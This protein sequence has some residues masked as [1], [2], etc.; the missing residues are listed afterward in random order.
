MSE[1]E[2]IILLE[3]DSFKRKKILSLVFKGVI[4]SIS[5]II[6]LFLVINSLEYSFQFGINTRTFLFFFYLLTCII[7]LSLYIGIP[8]SKLLDINKAIEDESAAKIIGQNFPEISDKLLNIIQLRKGSHEVGTLAY[9]GI[10][11]KID[12]IPS[13]KFD[14]A[15][16]NEANYKLLPWAVVPIIILVIV[17]FYRPEIITDS[18][19]R[20]TNY[21]KEYIPQAPFQFNLLNT[22]LTAF[23]N[24]DFKLELEITGNV[25][26]S[27][28]YLLDSDR[29]LKLVNDGDSRFSFEFNKIQ[30]SKRIKFEAAGFISKT[31]SIDVFNRPDLKSFNMYLEY[32]RYLHKKDERLS[33]V[34]NAQ[35]P[36]GT[37]VQWELRASETDSVLIDFHNQEPKQ[38]LQLS[39][40]ELFEYKSVITNSSNYEIILI[41]D[42]SKNRDQ[43]LYDLDV[44]KDAFPKINNQIYQD[45]ILYKIIGIG[46]S[47]IDDYGITKLKLF[48][49]I[50]N[51]SYDGVTI[52]LVNNEPNQRF[53]YTWQIDSLI[54]DNQEISYYL[55]VWDNDG[56]NGHKSTKTST[57]KLKVPS[58][59]E[60]KDDIDKM[61]QQTQSDID[62]TLKNAKELKEKLDE[63]ERKVKGK[64]ELNWQEN[65]LIKDL[66]ERREEL[67][68]A[69][70]ELKE[71]NRNNEMKR[72]RFSPQD[73]KIKEKVEQLQNLMDELLDE[74]TKKLYDELKRLLEEQENVEDIQELIEKINNKET[75]LENELERTLELFKKMKF[76]FDL[77]ETIA[78]LKEQIFDQEMLMRETERNSGKDDEKYSTLEQQEEKNQY[79][80]NNIKDKSSDYLKEKQEILQEDFSQLEEKLED[81]KKQNQSLKNPESLPD[82]E[83]NQKNVKEN[84]KESLENLKDNQRSKSKQSQQKAKDAMQKMADQL[85]KMQQGMEMQAMQENLDDLR[86]IIHNLIKLSFD[87][88]NLMNE[89]REVNQSDPRFVE[90][91]QQQLKLK[92][93]SQI[94][95]D[96][97]LALASRVFQ[98]ASFVT[99]E[100]TEMN[101]RMDKS[102]EF[103][104]ERKKP[105]AIAEQQFAMTSMNNLA[106]LLDDVLQQMQNAMADAMGK[107]SKNKGNQKT[108]S[109][110]ELQQ[111]LNNK[112]EELKGSGKEGRQLS[113]ELAKLAAEQER[114]RKALEN[115][116]KKASEMPNGNNPGDGI[117][118]KMEE[119]END[120]VNKQI[121]EKTIERQ[122][123]ILTRLLESEDALRER[124]KDEKRKGET[125]KDYNKVMPD[126]FEEYFKLKEQEIE[127]LKTIPPKLYP[128]YKEAVNEYFERI[129]KESSNKKSE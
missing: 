117:L 43:I 39:D 2:K 106:L 60:I 103:I 33:N 8:L 97:L 124:D 36:E 18:T 107:P 112:I 11:Q 118:E 116:Q 125:A 98:I 129:G 49:S 91:S 38:K 109:L 63:A 24:E 58:K 52:P 64:K 54:K 87:Q 65:K 73:E 114:I 12:Q 119:T 10:H 47:L 50:N 92:D 66:I 4:I 45:T 25:I 110:S 90:L 77:N 93:D 81:L 120:L 71:Q 3:I 15:I 17:L 6:S 20:I 14:S 85:D 115:A 86:A 56:F 41:N 9:A 61:S 16:K 80:K 113:E 29:K 82:T 78:E 74:E 123:E 44:V 35:V 46:G 94:V 108:P 1:K 89:F 96:S 30:S 127:F 70:E 84:Q 99:R 26:P 100:V 19:Q 13:I 69:I 34:G 40:N 126:A 122:K 88:E 102:V 105:Q 32:P 31:Y 28:V 83:E 21:N 104:R 128:Y 111:Q 67:D 62:K 22:S 72:D 57:Y 37:E 27:S 59:S 55:E 68:K 121:T 5:I 76:E 53:Y 101:E 7:L 51:G 79:D 75:N 23:K 48:Y 95:Q 42:K